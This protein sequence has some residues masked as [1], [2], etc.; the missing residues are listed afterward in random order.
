MNKKPI[1]FIRKNDIAFKNNLHNVGLNSD[2][3]VIKLIIDYPKIIERPIVVKGG[4][5]IIARPVDN[6]LKLL[7]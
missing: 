6:V 7:N 4:K 5:A 2:E 3:A 1:N